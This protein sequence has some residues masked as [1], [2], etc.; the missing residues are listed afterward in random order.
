MVVN[1]NRWDTADLSDPEMWSLPKMF[2]SA[3]MHPP[4]TMTNFET[5]SPSHKTPERYCSQHPRVSN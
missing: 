3:L 4:S 2:P 5:V 1:I